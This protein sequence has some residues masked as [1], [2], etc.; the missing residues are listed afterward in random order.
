MIVSERRKKV[1]YR[2]DEACEFL[3]CELDQEASVVHVCLPRSTMV[4]PIVL[5]DGPL[6]EYVRKIEAGRLIMLHE[7]DSVEQHDEKVGFQVV[8]QFVNLSGFGE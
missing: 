3:A 2:P 6:I 4:G 1:E 5:R 7:A 8:T